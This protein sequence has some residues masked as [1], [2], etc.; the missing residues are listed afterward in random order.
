V[1]ESVAITPAE[2]AAR[3]KE[4]VA[5]DQVVADYVPSLKRAGSRLKGLCP[6]HKEKTPSF[7]VHAEMGFY[8]CFGC[9]ARGDAIKF[10]QEIEKIDFMLALEL[11][12]RRAGLTMPSFRRSGG[13]S[14]AEHEERLAR[15]RELCT[16]A[17]GFFIEQLSRHPRG[18]AARQYLQGRD[19]TDDQ[20][21]AYRLG[22]APPGFDALL[23]EA[24]HRGWRPETL[25]EA[26]LVSR[27]DQGGF[28]DRFSDRIIFPIADRHGQIVAFAGRLLADR[29]DAPKYIN[30]AETPLFS[31]SKLLYGMAAAREAISQTRTVV[32]LEGYM[33]WLA[34][35]RQG[36]GNP[37]AGMG[38]ALSE[39]QARLLRRVCDRV[40]LL[41]DGDTAGRKA[42]FR[43]TEL[44]LRQGLETRAAPLPPEHDP[45][46]FLGA[47]GVQAMRDL[48][49]LAPPAL[50][51]FTEEI[52]R[53]S[54]LARPE[55]KAEAVGRL[56]P[57]LLAIKDPAL[58][59]GYME[60][61]ALRFGLRL[62]TLEAAI[63][64]RS[65]R[66]LR[67]AG[68]E[69]EGPSAVA[70]GH[71]PS[72]TEQNLLYLVVRMRDQLAGLPAI[73]PEWFQHDVVR[74]IFERVYAIHQ[75]LLEGADHPD[76]LFQICENENQRDWLSRVLLLPERRLAGEVAD[77]GQ[78]VTGSIELQVH[79][80]KRQWVQRRKRELGQ[81]L[82]MILA[83]TPLGG[84]Q[85]AAIDDLSRQSVHE[86]ALFLDGQ[87]PSGGEQTF[88][89]PGHSD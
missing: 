87:A 39:D 6:F 32:L 54:P 12:A 10:V 53:T 59:E 38:T 15:L 66:R 1:S 24:Q 83:E 78:Q 49:D 86:H 16:W 13:P 18:A 29:P 20:I 58:R 40:I 74:A 22:F 77:F 45:D 36:I 60:Q 71:E 26:G 80:L 67:E 42:M 70:G 34:L 4:R 5:I 8:Y 33:D 7:H 27:R 37:L 14:G 65:P 68:A 85:L 35:H 62:E 23:S 72:K 57:L 48:L 2:F 63:R 56:A 76:D 50:G 21:K 3:L 44:L 79:K 82:H 61:A 25:A 17:E 43:A 84:G 88:F 69:G 28:I 51:Y 89:P 47:E 55:G 73:E 81:D 9:Q 41:Y 64:R 11:L 30:S 19:L 31:K 52:A 46:S 75:H